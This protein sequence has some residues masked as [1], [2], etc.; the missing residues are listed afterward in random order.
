ML[1]V[2]VMVDSIIYVSMLKLMF[3]VP[4]TTKCC[5]WDRHLENYKSITG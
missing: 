5:M 4:L 2:V 1:F 3:N